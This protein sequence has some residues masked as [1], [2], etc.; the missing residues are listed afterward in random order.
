MWYYMPF[1]HSEN[2]HYQE[3]G[4]WKFSELCWELREGEWKETHGFIKLALGHAWQHFEAI[5]KFGRFPLRNKAM[6]RETTEEEEKYIVEKGGRAG[7][8]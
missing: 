5:D 6:G 8:Q 4:L 1:E 7:A 3:L 2:I